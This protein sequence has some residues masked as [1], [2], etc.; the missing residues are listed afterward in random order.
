MLTGE[1][2]LAKE[3]IGTLNLNGTGNYTGGTTIN[4]GTVR[5]GSNTAL[6]GEGNLYLPAGVLDLNGYAATIAG[7][8]DGGAGL[9]TVLGAS[10][11]L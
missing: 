11:H 9:G 10:G 2:G 5:L 3:T 1:I 6:V 4:N 8:N 7:L